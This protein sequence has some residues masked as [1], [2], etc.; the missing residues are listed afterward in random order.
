MKVKITLFILLFT[1]S[2]VFSQNVEIT[3]KILGGS[4]SKIKILNAMSQDL[5]TDSKVSDENEFEFNLNIEEENIF[6]LFLDKKNYMILDIKPDENIEISYNLNDLSKTTISGS[7]GSE[8]YLDFFKK[9][10]KNKHW[11]K[12]KQVEYIDSL[13]NANLNKFVSVVFAL[14]LDYG[15]NFETHEKLINSLED[16]FSENEL[17]KQYKAAFEKEKLTSIGAIAPDIDLPNPEG[18]N[19]KL[20]S[21][22]GNYVL[23]DFWAAWCR[24]CR[25]EN[26]NLVKAYKKYKDEGFTIYSI[27]LDDNK[28]DWTKAIEADKMGDWIH[29]SDLKGWKSAAGQAYGVSA[30]PA[31]FLIDP[32]GKI[33]AKDLRGKALEEKLSKIFSD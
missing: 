20:S 22:R 17:F 33:I 27:S 25:M 29:V 1:S 11:T 31:N 24:P 19:V 16:D 2:L 21:T 13:V 8:L 5:I 10:N 32:N 4:Y 28:E 9:L 14:N 6:L 18:D 7:E 12:A 15:E 30:I 26:P 3:G 23:I